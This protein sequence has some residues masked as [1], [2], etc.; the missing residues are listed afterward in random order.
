MNDSSIIV[1]PAIFELEENQIYTVKFPDLEGCF[2]QGNT[3][4]EALINSQEA[5]AIYY[6]EKK[7]EL[8]SASNIFEIK[9][10]TSKAIVQMVCVNL[11]TYSLKRI[12][13]KFVRKNLTIPE[14]LHDLSQK[15]DVNYSS[16]LKEAL[17]EHLKNNSKVSTY[18]KILLNN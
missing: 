1:Y 15:Y 6:Y 17:I 12:N 7:G 5:L 9:K 3:L 8:K 2:S 11:K 18:D 16:V 10:L 14:W 13:A 4:E